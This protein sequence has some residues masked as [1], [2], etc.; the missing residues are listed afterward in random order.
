[1]RNDAIFRIYSM[2]KP[3]V[4]VAVMMLFERGRLQLGDPLHKH[5]PEFAAVKVGVPRAD[6]SLD[7]V[8]P[9]R[10]INVHDLL[11][12]TAGLTYEFLGESPVRRLYAEAKIFS[13][14]RSNAEFCQTLAGL[15]LMHQPGSVWDYSRATDELGRLVEFLYEYAIQVSFSAAMSASTFA[16]AASVGSFV[17]SVAPPEPGRAGL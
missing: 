3:V 8:A 15:P 17:T 9:L 12:H 1:M 14:A 6:G 13:L 4:S 10:P 16:F 7:L 2:T 11:R 5:L